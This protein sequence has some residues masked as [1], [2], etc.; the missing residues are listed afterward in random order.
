MHW[1]SSLIAPCCAFLVA[2]AT[3][4]P[5]LV[6]SVAPIAAGLEQAKQQS[7]LA[8]TTT[9]QMARELDVARVLANNPPNLVEADF[10]NAIKLEDREKWTTAFGVLGTYTRDLQ[11][12][13]DPTRA[14]ATKTNLTA[15]ATELN[16]GSLQA[17]LPGPAVAAFS[18]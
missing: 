6:E 13:V 9:N 4:G 1:R 11:N 3:P 18:E 16:K 17:N 15:L 14:E 8:F 5:K 2:C 10:P 12:L 7:D